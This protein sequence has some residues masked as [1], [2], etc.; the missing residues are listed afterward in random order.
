MLWQIS[1]KFF[2]RVR[3]QRCWEAWYGEVRKSQ[4]GEDGVAGGEA[5]VR[6][7]LIGKKVRKIFK[8]LQVDVLRAWH[9][10]ARTR[11]EAGRRLAAKNHVWLQTVW[12]HLLTV[13]KAQ[14]GAKKSVV[15]LLQ[16]QAH[17]LRQRPFRAWHVLV[18]ERGVWRHAHEHLVRIRVAKRTRQLQKLAFGVWS[19]WRAAD[20][21]NDDDDEA[22]EDELGHLQQAELVT[23]VRQLQHANE[24]LMRGNTAARLFI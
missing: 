6:R 16:N 15:A 9:H 13:C 1:R 5:E 14:R 3:Y 20:A 10:S 23:M 12:G 17:A 21:E 4:Y 8:S 7:K 2:A 19:R 18:V 22:K 11:Q 24:Q